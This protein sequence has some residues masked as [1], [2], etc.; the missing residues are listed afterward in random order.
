[1]KKVYLAGAIN[2]MSD[3]D[4]KDWREE[5]IKKL[6]LL[7]FGAL[8]PMDRDYRGKEK[9]AYKEIVELDKLDIDNSAYIIV[10]YLKPSV[11]TSM[12]V[13]YAWEQGKPVVIFTTSDN[14][15][16]WLVYHST[17]I[18]KTLFEAIVEIDKIDKGGK[19]ALCEMCRL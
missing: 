10:N 2:K 15:S 3:A 12:E 5:A 18:V 8:N 16:P 19:S 1:M 14:V 9:T 7:G 4:C 17:K 11:G 6:A 13:L